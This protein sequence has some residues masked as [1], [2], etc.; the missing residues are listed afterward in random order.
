MYV[1]E[2]N[3][4]GAGDLDASELKAIS[5]SSCD[6]IDGIGS[7]N[8]TWLHSYVTGEKVYCVYLAKN[9]AFIEE[10]AKKGGFPANTIEQVAIII[11]PET[12]LE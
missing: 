3:I 8:I 5:R 11:D 1:I 10:H 12:A 2:R 4:P 6:V 9:K 7:G